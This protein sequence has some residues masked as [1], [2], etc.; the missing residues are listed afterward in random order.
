MNSLMDQIR[1]FLLVASL[2]FLTNACS[3]DD[4]NGFY[5]IDDLKGKWYLESSTLESFKVCPDEP[6]VLI[7]AD[8]EMELP[9]TDS[10]G[11]QTGSFTSDYVFD[12]VI[13]TLNFNNL[14]VAIKVESL[15]PHK[16]VLRY[17]SDT[18]TTLATEVYYR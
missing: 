12:G 14:V 2:C 3:R 17:S 9:V 10:N 4:E 8:N 18:E 16:L 13:F 15:S 6:P 7:I 11:C 5:N 1:R